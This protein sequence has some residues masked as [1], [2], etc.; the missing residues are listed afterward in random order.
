[1]SENKL[2]FLNSLSRLYASGQ[3]TQANLDKMLKDGVIDGTDYLYV[4]ERKED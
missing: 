3:I 2:I 4:T 1:M